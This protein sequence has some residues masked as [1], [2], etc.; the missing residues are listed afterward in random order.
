MADQSKP[1]VIWARVF[2]GGAGLAFLALLIW[3][4]VTGD[5]GQEFAV[6]MAMPWGQVTLADLY[7]G[8]FLYALVVFLVEEKRLS[9]CFWALPVFVLGNV[10][11][12]LWFVLRL[13]KI[14][15]RLRPP[16]V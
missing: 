12:A 8:F 6:V 11:A 3:A 15:E 10:W 9:A 5:F 14:I 2:I 1:N 4:A 16:T 13:P 7:L